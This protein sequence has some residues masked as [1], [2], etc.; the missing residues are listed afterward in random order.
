MFAITQPLRRAAKLWSSSP[1][2]LREEGALTWKELETGVAKFAQFLRDFGVSK[3]DRVAILSQNSES[4]FQFYMAAPWADVIMVSINTRWSE[5]E[6]LTALD[7]CGAIILLVDKQFESMGQ[8]LLTRSDSIRQVVNI[9][10]ES[11]LSAM[12]G[13]M[14]LRD[15][16]RCD[17]DTVALFYTG[18]TTG[19][20]KGVMLN[21][22]GLL[23]TGLQVQ[24]HS[25]LDHSAVVLHVAPFFHMAAGGIIYATLLAGAS[26]VVLPAFVPSV[27]AQAIQQHGVT[28]ILLVPTM[29]EMLLYDP[30]FSSYDLSSLRRI[31]YG[32]S[33]MPESLLRLAMERLP[34]VEF[35]QFYGMTELSP[36]ATVLPPEDHNKVGA[37]PSRL[38]SAGVPIELADLRI[39]DDQGNEVPQGQVGEVTVAGPSVMQ[40]YWNNPDATAAAIRGGYMH[41][42]D[43]GYC[44]EDGYLYLVDRIKDMI[45]SG[46]ENVYSTEVEQAVYQYPGVQECAVVGAPDPRWGESV[47]AVIYPEAGCTIDEVKIKEFCASK[48]ANYKCPKKV[49]ITSEPLPKTAAGKIAKTEIRKWVR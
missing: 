9:E 6:M 35:T 3:G 37:G 21:S 11:C 5:E 33:P 2:L 17:D 12:S 7:D 24:A 25:G 41:T 8:G 44:D 14:P 26:S 28:H 46:G 30:S 34:G 39:V 22:V 20:S 18:G 43:A 38:R 23:T 45:I 29:I 40:G 36:V 10:H 31:V 1:A 42:G 16:G 27:V 19:R 13:L 4:F 15:S 49:V 47:S 48:I 32:S